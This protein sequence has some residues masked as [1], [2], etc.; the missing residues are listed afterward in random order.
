MFSCDGHLLDVFH[1]YVCGILLFILFVVGYALCVIGSSSWLHSGLV[2]SSSLE[3]VWTLF[4]LLILTT[5]GFPRLFILY[6]QDVDLVV[7][8][9]LKVTGHQW[10]W[11]YDYSSCLRG[12]E[13]D[14]FMVPL[15]GLAF[16]E[17]RLLEVDNRPLLP[18]MVSVRWVVLSGDVL[19]SWALPSLCIKVDA[20]PGR[21]NFGVSHVLCGG[22]FYGQ[23][24][25]ICGAN[26]SFMPIC[27]EVVSPLLFGWWVSSG[28]S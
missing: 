9:T 2:E 10:Y 14:S 4:P 5:I 3:F 15:N 26:H 16:G 24:R 21:L 6:S 8:L 20:T 18:A 11:R 25:E 1:S 12:L 27:L 23:C 28:L 22:L 19:H 17:F 7:D 13:F